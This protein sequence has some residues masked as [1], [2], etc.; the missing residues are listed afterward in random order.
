MYKKMSQNKSPAELRAAAAE[1]RIRMNMTHRERLQFDA[2]QARRLRR[3]QASTSAPI[4][5][6]T[7]ARSAV[8]AQRRFQD[9]VPARS[10]ASAFSA[11]SAHSAV[12]A[13][14]QVFDT[15]DMSFSDIELAKALAESLVT[16]KSEELQRRTEALV[17]AK[18]E[19]AD[20]AYAQEEADFAYAQELAANDYSF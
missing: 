16:A 5:D 10:V 3:F 12:S 19:E 15:R 2:E 4:C 8:P 6:T 13:Q 20:F 11:V 18:Q 17:K 7:P 14:R 9:S 1:H